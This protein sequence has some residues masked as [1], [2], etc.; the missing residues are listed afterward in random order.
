MKPIFLWPL[1]ILLSTCQSVQGHA[2]GLIYEPDQQFPFGRRNPAAPA[3]LAQLDFMIGR[4]QCDEEKLNAASGEWESGARSWDAYY[5]MNGYAIRDSG[6]SGAST[7]GNIR[8]F[9]VLEKQWKVS[10]FSMPSYGTG[11]WA[12][13]LEGENM[14]LMQPQKAPSTDFDGF[15]R[16]TFSNISS[17]GFDWTG[18]WVSADDSVVFTFWRIQCSKVSESA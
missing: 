3:E 17:Q 18:E 10:F 5:F 7:N 11:V 12:G 4:N 16:L 9:D 2:P 1:L 14:V 6:R 8:L 15:S 13:G